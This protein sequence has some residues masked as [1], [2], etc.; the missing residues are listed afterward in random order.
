MRKHGSSV[1]GQA[2]VSAGGGGGALIWSEDVKGMGTH[3]LYHPNDGA[4]GSRDKHS[5]A[6]PCIQHP[7]LDAHAYTKVRHTHIP[8]RAILLA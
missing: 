8:L 2:R 3:S 1:F 6:F 7:H 4:T 5:H